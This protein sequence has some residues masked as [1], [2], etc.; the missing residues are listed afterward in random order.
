MAAQA[1]MVEGLVYGMVSGG[2]DYNGYYVPDRNL[3]YTAQVL[4]QQ[5]YPEF[6][7]SMREIAGG[8]LI[9]LPSSVKDLSLIHI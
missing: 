2:G 4:T 5:L 8:G 1:A 9:M 6:I 3:M 7:T